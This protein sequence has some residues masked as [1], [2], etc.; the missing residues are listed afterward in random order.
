MQPTI[1]FIRRSSCIGAACSLLFCATAWGED[2]RDPTRPPVLASESPV[3]I[4]APVVTAASL[5]LEGIV[6]QG[7]R[8]FAIIDGQVVRPGSWVGDARIDVV[9]PD[10]VHYTRAGQSRIARFETTPVR[11][12]RTVTTAE[13][14]S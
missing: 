4:S 10:E 2:L 13:E 11:V 6:R 1:T 5:R 7:A 12:R 8:V 14:R 9:T 3:T